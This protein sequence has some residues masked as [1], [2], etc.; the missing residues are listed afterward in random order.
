M[1][2][3][4]SFPLI[5]LLTILC[6]CSSSDDETLV[7]NGG[8][9]LRQLT[10]TQVE[11][12]DVTRSLSDLTRAS[13]TENV[14]EKTLSA[15]WSVGDKLS[16]CNISDL[17]GDPYNCVGYLSAQST[18]V[19]STFTGE[20]LCA[21]GDDIAV[22]YPNEKISI[23]PTTKDVTFSLN[24]TGQDG[25]LESLA[26]YYHFICGLAKITTVTDNTASAAIQMK[27]LLTI[28]KFSFVDENDKPIS[29]KDLYICY[30]DD[31][32]KFEYPTSASITVTSMSTFDNLNAEGVID[33]N[34]K[35]LSIK[36]ADGLNEVYVALVP[37]GQWK[38]KFVVINVDGTTYEGKATATLKAGKFV[39]GN[40]KLT[41]QT[42][43]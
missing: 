7:N 10:I 4:Y 32:G 30:H 37:K 35:I 38:Y 8:R 33:E 6:G 40:L 39:F 29:V 11:D 42:N 16:L 21:K 41:K 2:T 23:K 5:L 15:S 27:S 25:T 36:N 1:N 3:K 34:N 28:C 19:K 31:Y 9:K 22:A 43:N 26:K 18:A 14:A 12:S 20:I 24:L 13:I 17:Y